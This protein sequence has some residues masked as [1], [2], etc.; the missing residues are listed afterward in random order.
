[1]IIV[2]QGMTPQ[3]LFDKC[4]QKFSSWKY[5]DRNLD[6]IIRSDRTSK[7]GAY[8]VW[9]RDRVEADEENK[10]LSAEQVKQQGIAGITLEERLLY[11]LKFFKETGNH[12]DISNWTLCSGSRVS[13]SDVP[14]VDWDGRL[15]VDWYNPRDA[16]S[17]LRVRSAVSLP[18]EARHNTAAGVDS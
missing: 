12:L 5:T 1:L 6:K 3:R 18:R 14:G 15:W 2:A 17:F 9:V 8:A 16:N 4:T 10:N 7:D 11:E 13:D